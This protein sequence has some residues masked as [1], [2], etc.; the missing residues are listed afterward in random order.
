MT[1]NDLDVYYEIHGTGNPIV[2]I[3]GAWIDSEIWDEQVQYF[4]KTNQ[5]IVYDIRGHGRTGKGSTLDYSMEL[6]AK[7]VYQLLQKLSIHRPIVCG[8]SMG[9]LV[10]QAYASHYPD[11]LKALILIG[12][13]ASSSLTLPDKIITHVL[14]PYWLSSTI[15]RIIGSKGL[16]WLATVYLW[17]MKSYEKVNHE[18][19][20]QAYFKYVVSKHSAREFNKILKA[21]Y[22]FTLQDLHRIKVPTAIINGAKE[23]KIMFLHAHELHRRISDSKRF[24]ISNAGH[25]PN[26]ERPIET[27]RTIEQFIQSIKKT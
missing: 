25:I 14:A 16:A 19:N 15:V 6:Y 8:L 5:V 11:N 27:N 13:I 3:H 20:I 18:Q 10:A 17:L 21:M 22:C 23:L 4:S 26:V 1:V 9:A 2:L 12:A 24:V 7:D